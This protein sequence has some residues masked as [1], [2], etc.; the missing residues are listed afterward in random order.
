LDNIEGL[1]WTP[2]DKIDYWVTE[3]YDEDIKERPSPDGTK[4]LFSPRKET[5]SLW[6]KDINATERRKLS[7]DA[8]F[9][10]WINNEKISFF[11]TLDSTLWIINPD[12]TRLEKVEGLDL[13]GI[14]GDS[15]ISWTPD[16][17]KVAFSINR[18]GSSDIWVAEI[19]WE[20]TPEQPGFEIVLSL[21]LFLLILLV[22]LL[23]R[24]SKNE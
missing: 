5:S 11:N 17:K 1:Q 14:S 20:E 8:D 19:D 6:I 9:A 15:P 10:T 16:G 3:W 18:S 24:V 4:V 21:F 2:D 22:L 23:G 7:E 12:G 13:S